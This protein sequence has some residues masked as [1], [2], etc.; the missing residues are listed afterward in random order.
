MNQIADQW[1]HHARHSLWRMVGAVTATSALATALASHNP[2]STIIALTTGLISCSALLAIIGHDRHHRPGLTRLIMMGLSLTS[3]QDDLRLNR[4][5]R[6]IMQQ[7]SRQTAHCAIA[8]MGI[9]AFAALM[10]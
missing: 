7:I 10:S 6:Q 5:M 1:E 9:G 3:Q 2:Q 4:K 8:M